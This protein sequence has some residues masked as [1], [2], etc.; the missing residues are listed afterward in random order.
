MEV[1]FRLDSDF[2]QIA[3]K[4]SQQKGM[5]NESDDKYTSRLQPSLLFVLK[6]L[7]PGIKL[8]YMLYVNADE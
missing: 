2:N 1:P 6:Q 8:L 7:Q 5:Y 4:K 3:D